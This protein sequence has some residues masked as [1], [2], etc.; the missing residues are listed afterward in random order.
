[1]PAKERTN[2]NICEWLTRAIAVCVYRRT[3][4]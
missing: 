3:L 4:D 2:P 1:M